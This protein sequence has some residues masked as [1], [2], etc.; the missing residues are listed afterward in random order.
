M[1]SD[2]VKCCKSQYFVRCL[3]S[4]HKRA[5]LS[6]VLPILQE[7]TRLQIEIGQKHGPKDSWR[8]ETDTN[9]YTHT[10]RSF[11][12]NKTLSP[13]SCY[14][15]KLLYTEVFTRRASTHRRVYSQNC[16][17]ESE[18]FIQTRF[19]TE[20]LSHTQKF[21]PQA[22]SLITQTDFRNRSF[23]MEKLLHR[24]IFAQRRLY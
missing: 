16:Y 7:E 19:H 5:M 17:T 24:D 21:S 11:C 12:T 3:C 10:Q 6:C 14:T 22:V 15:Q 9:L 20:K 4:I 18:V 2:S 8:E 13:K 1:P 23:Y